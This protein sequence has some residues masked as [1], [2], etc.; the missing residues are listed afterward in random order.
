MKITLTKI[1]YSDSYKALAVHATPHELTVE[2][3]DNTYEHQ[4]QTA[5]FMA[6]AKQYSPAMADAILSAD[7]QV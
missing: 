2:I 7:F 6:V 3:P 5:V 4:M 1:E